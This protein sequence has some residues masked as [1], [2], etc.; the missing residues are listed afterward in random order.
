MAKPTGLQRMFRASAMV[1]ELAVLV[2][3]AAFAGAWLDGRL[4]SSPLFLL[5]CST[6]AL[7]A[8]LYRI[9]RWL[10]TEADGHHPP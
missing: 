3:V 5:L 1:T 10:G 7:V 9:I 4:G 6:L 8:G 2:L